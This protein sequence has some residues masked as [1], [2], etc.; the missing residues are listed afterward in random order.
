MNP[1]TFTVKAWDGKQE[2]SRPI[3]ALPVGALFVHKD[4]CFRS[5]AWQKANP[6]YACYTEP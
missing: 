1:V 6:C 4:A 2:V 3:E 5:R